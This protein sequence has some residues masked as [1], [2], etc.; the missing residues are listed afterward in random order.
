MSRWKKKVKK[1]LAKGLSLKEMCVSFNLITFN[2]I[3][4]L[5]LSAVL[6]L[7]QDFKHFKATALAFTGI[8][9]FNPTFKTIFPYY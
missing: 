9:A 5:F 7:T 3:Q 6:A 1:V 2:Y 8:Y 4:P